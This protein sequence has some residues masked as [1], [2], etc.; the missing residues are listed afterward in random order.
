MIPVII[1][2]RNDRPDGR[3]GLRLY[4]VLLKKLPV[5]GRKGGHLQHAVV[6]HTDFYALFCLVDEDLQNAPPHKALF[7]DEILHEDELFGFFK[8]FEH[9]LELVF[10]K[11]KIRNLRPVIDRKTAAVVQVGDQIVRAAFVVCKPLPGLLRLRQ[12]FF[13]GA[14]LL[15]DLSEDPAVAKIHLRKKQQSRAGDRRNGNDKHPCELRR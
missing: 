11:R 4:A 14:D 7:N 9:C 12:R 6:H 10:S 8:L 13:C 15:F 1:M 5:I 2:G 3:K